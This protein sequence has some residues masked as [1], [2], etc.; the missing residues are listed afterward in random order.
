LNS[1]P[2]KENSAELFVVATPLGN[3]ED[4]SFRAVR[5]LQEVSLIA[6]EDTRRVRPLFAH[7]G[8]TTPV[9]SCHLQNEHIIARKLL[10]RLQQGQSIALISDAGTPLISDPGFP[11]VVLAR[12]RGFRVIPVPGPS[13]MIAALS[14]AGLPVDRFVFEGFLPSRAAARKRRLQELATELRTLVFYESSH[15]IVASLQAMSELFGPERQAVVARELTKRFETVFKAG[16]AELLTMICNSEL[17]QKGEFVVVVKGAEQVASVEQQQLIQ[18]MVRLCAY[19]PRKKAAEILA[20]WT[21]EKKN[22]LYGL[23]ME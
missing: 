5:V 14:V 2:S 9:Q 11:L 23:G 8:I 3:L 18:M 17:Q 1:P 6:V 19:M 10:Q 16:L 7:Y 21:G 13:A 22:R 15:R 4:M 20:D 12:D